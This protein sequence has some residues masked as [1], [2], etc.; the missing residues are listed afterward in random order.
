MARIQ[1]V[2]IQS[3]VGGELGIESVVLLLTLADGTWETR[4]IPL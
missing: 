2:E 3:L 4:E 1:S